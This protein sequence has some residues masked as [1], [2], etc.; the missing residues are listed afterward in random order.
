MDVR[1]AILGGTFLLLVAAVLAFVI[2]LA[3]AAR[4]ARFESTPTQYPSSGYPVI[5][6]SPVDPRTSAFEVGSGREDLSEALLAP[7][8]DEPWIPPAQ[9][10]SPAQLQD[11]ALD[12]RIARFQPAPDIPEPAFSVETYEEWKV[13]APTQP[14]PIVP[15]VL[16]AE[17][18]VAIQAPTVEAVVAEMDEDALFDAEIAAL[19]PLAP[20]SAPEPLPAPKPAPEPAPAPLPEPA[21][22]PAPEPAPE[23]APGPLPA[24]APEPAPAPAPAPEPEPEPQPAPAPE[25]EPAE[26]DDESVWQSIM[27]E[28]QGLPSIVTSTLLPAPEPVAPLPPLPE[29]PAAVVHAEPAPQPVVAEE[30]RR[31]R[32]ARPSV[33]VA[34]A[35]VETESLEVDVRTIDTQA[36]ARDSAPEIRMA[37]PVEMW[38]GSD[39]VGVKAGTKTYD[40]FMKYAGVLLGDLQES[41]SAG[42]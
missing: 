23:L 9:P 17:P 5:T 34:G 25:P 32:P 26:Q 6:T 28:E 36:S 21:A 35:Y 41:K 18:V 22:A 7:M 42:R 27:R 19:M 10:A 13:A 14:I 2:T 39:R 8:S 29:R 31:Q 16:R 12:E 11:I 40:Q 15:E 38:F 4:A 1:V 30:P 24:P 33:R 3:R 20:P 37:A